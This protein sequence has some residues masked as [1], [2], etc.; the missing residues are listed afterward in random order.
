MVQ[1]EQGVVEVLGPLLHLQ[2]IW[3]L[4][5]RLQ[6]Q[7]LRPALLERRGLREVH[8]ASSRQ[9]AAWLLDG[10]L[11]DPTHQYCLLTDGE[12]T[13]GHSGRSGFSSLFPLGHTRWLRR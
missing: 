9:V 3:V 11:I 13:Y 6:P 2:L 4:D 12:N 8:W 5:V 1:E 10:C 7:R